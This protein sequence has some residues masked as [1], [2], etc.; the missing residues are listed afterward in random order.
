MSHT[1]ISD[2]KKLKLVIP[3]LKMRPVNLNETQFVTAGIRLPGGLR[4][5]H[6]GGG[7]HLQDRHGRRRHQPRRGIR[8][9]RP[10]KFWSQMEYCWSQIGHI[11]SRQFDEEEQSFLASATGS[12]KSQQVVPDLEV[13][14]GFT[15]REDI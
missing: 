4:Q 2:M 13:P 3:L 9:H 11:W 6:R 7:R 5:R 10:G 8:H 12:V 1:Q 14:V 15:V